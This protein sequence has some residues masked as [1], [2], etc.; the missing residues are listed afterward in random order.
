MS[1]EHPTGTPRVR[2]PTTRTSPQVPQRQPDAVRLRNSPEPAPLDWHVALQAT[3]VLLHERFGPPGSIGH[4]AIARM[5]QDL[6]A[7]LCAYDEI[8]AAV[9]HMQVQADLPPAKT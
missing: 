7:R 2:A 9:D 6:A 3:E 4:P 1:I 8:T 5:V